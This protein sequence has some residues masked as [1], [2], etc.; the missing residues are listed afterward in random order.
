M[1][2]GSFSTRFSDLPISTDSFGCAKSVSAGFGLKSVFSLSIDPLQLIN[3]MVSRVAIIL[4]SRQSAAVVGAKVPAV[5]GFFANL[6]LA[7]TFRSTPNRSRR[8]IK[9]EKMPNETEHKVRGTQLL[10][11][12]LLFAGADGSCSEFASGKYRVSIRNFS[13]FCWWAFVHSWRAC[14]QES[15]RPFSPSVHLYFRISSLIRWVIR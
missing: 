4:N 6:H 5:I 12:G 13:Y 2:E 14:S 9:K 8:V 10:F 1:Y 3:A 11:Y 15:L 7:V